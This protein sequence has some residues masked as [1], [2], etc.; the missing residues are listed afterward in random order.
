MF[1]NPLP[2]IGGHDHT[3]RDPQGDVLRSMRLPTGLECQFRWR[4]RPAVII[5][6]LLS[7]PAKALRLS[8]PVV[9]GL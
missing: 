6:K 1:G 3:D 4:L 7:Q 5:A 2:K 8:A 9:N